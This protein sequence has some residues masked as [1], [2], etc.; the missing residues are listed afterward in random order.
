M[1]PRPSPAERAEAAEAEPE[2]AEAEPEVAEAEPEPAEDG[3]RGR[4]WSGGGRR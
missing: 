3:A 1:S 4:Q 2:A